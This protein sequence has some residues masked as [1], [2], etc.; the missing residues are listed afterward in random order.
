MPHLGGKTLGQYQLIES[1]GQ[2]GM[3]EIYVAYQP[4]VK[5]EVVV[6][7]LSHTLRDEPSFVQQFM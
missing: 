1:I 7:V 4:S 3:A 6:K 5:R 2:G